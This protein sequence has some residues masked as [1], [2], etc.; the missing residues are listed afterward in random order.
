MSVHAALMALMALTNAKTPPDE[1]LC[2]DE[3]S[4]RSGGLRA[5]PHAG[6]MPPAN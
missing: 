5:N 2:V 4:E 1:G 6:W 3:L